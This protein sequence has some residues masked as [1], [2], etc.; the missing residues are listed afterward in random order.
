[1]RRAKRPILVAL[2]LLLAV[3]GARATATSSE[4]AR[5]AKLS[6]KGVRALRS[7]Q[8][9]KAREAF[10]AALQAIPDFPGARIGLGQIAMSEAEFA[11]ALEH[12][13]AARSGYRELGESLLD[14]EARRY[15][16]AQSE[17]NALE[18]SIRHLQTRI[19]ADSMVQIEIQKMVNKITQLQAIVP[20]NREAA[21]EPPG[22]IYFHIG[23]A[24]FQL[25]RTEEALEA[26]E[27]CRDRYPAFPMVHNNL[28][29]AYV[30]LERFEA[31]KESLDRAEEL[32]FPVNAQF[33]RDVEKAILERTAGTAG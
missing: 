20:P 23:N 16:A 15:G 18:D 19:A 22:E 6:N 29:H 27:T 12:F 24:L 1:M 9:E 26:W 10:G 4:L 2:T 21:G 30:R 31:A 28:A 17:I 32:G 13:E 11:E 8:I 14:I 3:A 7:G 33:K 25:G 5:A